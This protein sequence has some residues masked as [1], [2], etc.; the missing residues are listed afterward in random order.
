LLEQEPVPKLCDELG[1]Q[2]TVFY[3][4]QKEFFENGAAA[5]QTKARANLQAKQERIEYLE[6]KIQRKDEV[7]AELTGKHIAVKKSWE[8]LSAVWVPHDVRDQIVNF[9][10]GWPEASEISA[11]RFIAW[12]GVTASKFYS[13]RKRYGR[14][15]EHNGWVLRDFWWEDWE[16]QAIIGFHLKHPPEGYR[17]PTFMMLDAEVVAV[18]PATVWRVLSHDISTHVH[19]D[20]LRPAAAGLGRRARTAARAATGRS[21]G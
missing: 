9:V 14:A 8:T 16:K 4:W 6:K 10:R 21:G 5:F 2:G 18:S 19:R 11:W 17:R 3:R 20:P 13:W 15:N 12:L 7:R 1:L